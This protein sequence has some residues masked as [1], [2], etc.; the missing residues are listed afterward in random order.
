[1]KDTTP[2]IVEATEFK[3]ELHETAETLATMSAQQAILELEMTK[4]MLFNP[5]EDVDRVDEVLNLALNKIKTLASY[6]VSE[7]MKEEARIKQEDGSYED[8]IIDHGANVE[9][10]INLECTLAKAITSYSKEIKECLKEKRMLAG[11]GYGAR[12]DHQMAKTAMMRSV[13]LMPNHASTMPNLEY[14][15]VMMEDPDP[16]PPQEIITIDLES[17][18]TEE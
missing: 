7:L 5:K 12:Q 18:E 16:S 17:T 8:I 2:Q 13:K 6:D 14:D 15:V 1:M 9:Q 3:E 4:E 10:L 11:Q